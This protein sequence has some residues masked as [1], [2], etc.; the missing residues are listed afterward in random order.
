METLEALRASQLA[1]GK[2]LAIAADLTEF[3]REIFGLANSLEV[4]DLSGNRLR[5]LPPDFG[6]LKKLKIAFFS[7]NQFE[8]LPSVLSRCPALSMVGFKSNQIAEFPEH[9]LPEQLRWLILTD[10]RLTQLPASIGRLGQLQKLML[11]GNRLRSLPPELVACHSLE[12]MRL[13]ANALDALPEWLLQLPRLAW[14]AVS[15]NPAVS[16]RT[17]TPATATGALP[18]IDWRE[19]TLGETL[20]EGASGVISKAVWQQNSSPREVA[21]KLFK[22]QVTSDGFPADEM[23]ACIA[24]GSH[25]NLVQVL[26]QLI[27]APR[28]QAGLVLS[29]VSPD[30]RNLG[31]P[32]N[33]DTCTRDT[34]PPDTCFS[35]LMVLRIAQGIAGVAAHLHEQSILH[36]DLYAHNIL[37]NPAGDCVLGDFGAASRYG[38]LKSRAPDVAKGLERIEVRAFGYLLED[39]LSRCEVASD[40]GQQRA[41]EKLRQLQADCL[42]SA[43]IQ[44]GFKDLCSLLVTV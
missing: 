19:L 20:G 22:G 13:S 10:N 21:V 43:A 41:I 18:Q 35:L 4:L 7:H 1:G 33:F 12:L 40:V 29:L 6:R 30:Y 8:A 42:G 28:S 32:P 31:H 5:S 38:M 9:S 17:S 16:A 39:L 2:R 34:Y 26:G 3:P 24:A 37:V 27:N 25:Q 14:L 11:A 44:G 23:A 15:G 36:G